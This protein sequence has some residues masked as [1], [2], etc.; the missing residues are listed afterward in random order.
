MDECDSFTLLS[1]H[2]QKCCQ[3]PPGSFRNFSHVGLSFFS[4]YRVT[5]IEF[6]VAIGAIVCFELLNFKIQY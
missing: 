3:V 1:R 2:T 4:A 5:E 6:E